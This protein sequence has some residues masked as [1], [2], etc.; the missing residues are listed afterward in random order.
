MRERPADRSDSP[1]AAVVPAVPTRRRLL[2]SGLAAAPVVATLTSRPVLGTPHAT[3]SA[4]PSAGASVA[5]AKSASNG[6]SPEQWAEAKTWPDP[7][8]AANK[9]SAA[10]A[11]PYHGP[12]TGLAGATFAGTTM[13]AV[14]QLPDDDG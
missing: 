7:Y 10:V 6:R 3:A 12:A 2:K 8:F 11:T 4:G 9:S 13:L 1:S 5:P 14:L